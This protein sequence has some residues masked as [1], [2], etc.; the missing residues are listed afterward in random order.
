MAETPDS[1]LQMPASRFK[2]DEKPHRANISAVEF[3]AQFIY[4]SL[5]PTG[6]IIGYAGASA[7][8]GY[9]EC[10]GAAIN[11]RAYK[12]LF[13]VIGTTYGVGDGSTTFNIPTAAQASNM[14]GGT[15][16]A[17]TNQGFMMIR[18]G[19]F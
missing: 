1:P 12:E 2:E 5:V 3:F 9:L 14:F 16:A 4:G 18:T 7:P 13:S 17:S 19:A 11:R 15:N 10:N 6:G 8:A